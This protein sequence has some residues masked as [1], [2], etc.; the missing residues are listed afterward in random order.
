MN[1]NYVDVWNEL[2]KEFSKKKIIKYDDWL[3]KYKDIVDN[4]NDDIIDLG[5]GVTG[6]NTIYLLEEGKNVIS[7]DFDIE[8]LNVVDKI[9]GSK[10]L[11]FDMLEKFPF[12]DNYTSMIVAD[13]SLHYFRK[14]DTI[15]IIREI[16]RVLKKDGYLFFRLNSTNSTEY[17]KLVESNVDKVEDNLFFSKGMLKRFFDEE[18]IKF[19]FKDFD[20]ISLNEENMSRWST[21]KIVW[22]G[23]VR[24]NNYINKQL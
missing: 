1:N 15:R 17:K 16:S 7:C 10:T 22:K 5:C 12:E 11:C 6:N 23:L 24:K 18:D 20:I 14:E 8:A 3:D 13:L 19:Y 2:H 9:K 21:D 4:V